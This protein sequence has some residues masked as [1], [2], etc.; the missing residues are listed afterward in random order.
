MHR[1]NHTTPHRITL[2]PSP[3]VRP[4]LAM[5]TPQQVSTQPKLAATTCRRP[6]YGPTVV[7]HLAIVRVPAI[8]VAIPPREPAKQRKPRGGNS[9]RSALLHPSAEAGS[10]TPMS[11]AAHTSTAANCGDQRTAGVGAA[12]EPGATSL[13]CPRQREGSTP[14]STQRVGRIAL[15]C[16]P[17]QAR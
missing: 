2:R 1:V 8:A 3:A 13:N 11:T 17:L 6:T 12:C 5:V 10:T 16:S 9:Y 14:R 7:E 4:P 15:F